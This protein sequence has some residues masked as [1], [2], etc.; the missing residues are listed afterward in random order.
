ML[1]E[2]GVV[3]NQDFYTDLLA[4]QHYRP[5][6]C[7]HISISGENICRLRDQG[8]DIDSETLMLSLKLLSANREDVEVMQDFVAQEM[9]DGP[10]EAIAE[11]TERYKVRFPNS[12]VLL[13]V[14]TGHEHHWLCV[15]NW[16]DYE[17]TCVDSLL[18]DLAE[19][20]NIRQHFDRF[21]TALVALGRNVDKWTMIA[22]PHLRQLGG[23]DC[24]AFVYRHAQQI[25]QT[26]TTSS[27]QFDGQ[28][29]RQEMLQ[30]I[31]HS[32]FGRDRCLVC[33]LPVKTNGPAIT[34]CGLCERSWHV[35]CFPANY[36]PTAEGFCELCY[37]FVD[38][39]T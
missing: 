22:S 17:F 18:T 11:M 39:A 21:C 35:G 9:F 7:Q 37:T 10:M 19:E 26:G 34:T 15:A 32:S 3:V 29:V 13:M 16:E 28:A 12:G 38:R 6:T 4:G 25:L 27:G 24:G 2:Q 23:R 8:R 33:T 36:S 20:D 30:S 5:V 1:S 31:L 14:V